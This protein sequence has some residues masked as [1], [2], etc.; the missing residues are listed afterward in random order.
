MKYVFVSDA[1]IGENSRLN[2]YQKEFHEPFLLTIFNWVREQKDVQDLVLLGDIFDSWASL[3]GD[4]PAGFQEY[5]ERNPRL[6]TRQGE[7]ISGCLETVLGDVVFLNGNHDQELREEDLAPL[8]IEG[9]ALKYHPGLFYEPE[10]TGICATHGHHY[11]LINAPDPVSQNCFPSLGYFAARAAAGNTYRDYLK[12]STL[13]AVDLPANAVPGFDVQVASVLDGALRELSGPPELEF[14]MGKALVRGIS[15]LAGAQELFFRMPRCYRGTVLPDLVN[16]EMLMRQFASLYEDYNSRPPHGNHSTDEVVSPAFRAL[17]IGDSAN[18]LSS[19]ALNLNMAC[20]QRKVVVMGHTHVPVIER[21]LGSSEYLYVNSG[22]LCP[23]IPDYKEEHACT[24][25]VVQLL[26]DHFRVQILEP[27]PRSFS[28]NP[29]S[30][31]RVVFQEEL[32]R[33]GLRVM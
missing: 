18:T 7:G 9:R 22:F 29:G 4:S 16:M 8:A 14:T 5:Y 19:F 3:P 32:K 31:C 25:A 26:P 23:A 12:N 17:S 10:G 11:S 6:F 20:P 1:H 33:G 28:R 30:D 13:K 15:S 27:L 24:F 21:R 2:F